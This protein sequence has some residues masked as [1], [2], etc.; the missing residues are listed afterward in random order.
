MRTYYIHNNGSL[1]FKIDIYGT[2]V[3]IYDQDENYN[4]NPVPFL[5]F[6]PEKIYIGESPLNTRTRHNNQY[7]ASFDGN[8]I[9]LKKCKN[10]YISIT[11]NIFTF[12][13]TCDIKKY[14]SPIGNNDVPYPYAIDTNNNYYLLTE[15]VVI[16]NIPIGDDPYNYYYR[17]N[18]ITKNMAFVIPR[19]PTI[20]N[21]HNIKSFY[22]ENN[23]YTLTYA[24]YAH[25]DYDDL[26]LRI[27]CPFYII[28]TNDDKYVLTK[29]MY[30]KLM[31]DFGMEMGFSPL[32]KIVWHTDINL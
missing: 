22:I 1:P 17:N 5:E 2:D 16:K 10:T 28:D 25:N 19:M 6:S 30:I 21:F 27:G 15:N 11:K 23:Q 3:K 9:L 32:N 29:E 24:P 13:T 12:K 8:T 4:Y 14:V 7:G 18:L 20:A 26:V 31:N